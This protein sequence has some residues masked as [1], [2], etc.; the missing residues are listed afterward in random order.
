[1]NPVDRAEI[2]P[3]LDDAQLDALLAYWDAANYLTAA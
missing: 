2:A 3:S 1:M